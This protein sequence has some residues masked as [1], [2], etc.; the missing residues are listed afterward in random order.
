[1]HH[2]TMVHNGNVGRC[3]TPMNGFHVELFEQHI[4]TFNNVLKL[5]FKGNMPC[6][7]HCNP[8]GCN[9]CSSHPTSFLSS[10][11]IWTQTFEPKCTHG[12]LKVLPC[13]TSNVGWGHW[14]KHSI[15]SL[16]EQVH[17]FSPKLGWSLLTCVMFLAK[18]KTVQLSF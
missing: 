1:M 11:R 5:V 15:I 2:D 16:V 9:A 18:S 14:V 4:S 17:Y 12:Q 6:S 3:F 13:T 7:S 8:W 10:P